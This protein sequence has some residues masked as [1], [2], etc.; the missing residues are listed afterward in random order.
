MTVLML[1]VS[2]KNIKK[3]FNWNLCVNFLQDI[4]LPQVKQ[5]CQFSLLMGWYYILQSTLMEHI[6]IEFVFVLNAMLFV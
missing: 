6:L 4:L 5:N 3:D 2:G 1:N